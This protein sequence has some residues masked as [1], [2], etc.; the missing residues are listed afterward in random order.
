M[1]WCSIYRNGYWE[2]KVLYYMMVCKILVQTFLFPHWWILK[3]ILTH[4]SHCSMDVKIWSM[5]QSQNF[6]G[7]QSVIIWRIVCSNF[8]SCQLHVKFERWLFHVFVPFT[9]MSIL[10]LQIYA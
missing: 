5:T 1:E 4:F 3:M 7:F 6:N 2:A 8:H 10:C 9:C